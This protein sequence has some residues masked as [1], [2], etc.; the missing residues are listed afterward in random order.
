MEGWLRKRGAKIRPWRRRYF[1]FY[2]GHMRY[3]EDEKVFSPFS[4]PIRLFKAT[5]G[6]GDN[7]E[8]RGLDL[9]GRLHFARSR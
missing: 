3:F 9:A 8:G 4:G 1:K 2:D 5:M 6:I 7:H